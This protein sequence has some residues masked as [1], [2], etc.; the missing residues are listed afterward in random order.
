MDGGRIFQLTDPQL[1]LSWW[2]SFFFAV[3]TVE[4]NLPSRRHVMVSI[5]VR[6]NTLHQHDISPVSYINTL[7]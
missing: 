7:I 4:E 1:F 6:K 2:L 5:L 3:F